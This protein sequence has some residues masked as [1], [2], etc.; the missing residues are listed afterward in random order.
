MPRSH[1]LFEGHPRRRLGLYVQV[2]ANVC[3]QY[4]ISDKPLTTDEWAAEFAKDGA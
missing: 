1:H 4:W 3:G 2:N